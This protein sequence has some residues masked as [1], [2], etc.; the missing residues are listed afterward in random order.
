LKPVFTALFAD[1]CVS[2]PKHSQGCAGRY[3]A[4]LPYAGRLTCL[5]PGTFKKAKVHPARFARKNSILQAASAL[6]YPCPGLNRKILFILK[7]TLV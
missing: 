6:L 7:N 3:I 2:T 5:S 4:V 1:F